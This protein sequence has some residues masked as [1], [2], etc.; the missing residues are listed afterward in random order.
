MATSNTD[1]SEF[2]RPILQVLK[3]QNIIKDW[4]VDTLHYTH[5]HLNTL[6]NLAF[7]TSDRDVG[8]RSCDELALLYCMVEY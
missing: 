3:D 7:L 2:T 1:E 4:N 5:R 6:R 8:L